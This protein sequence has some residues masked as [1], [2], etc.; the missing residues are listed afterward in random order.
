ML[1]AGAGLGWNGRVSGPPVVPL[2]TAR[3]LLLGAQGLLADPQRPATP[4][5]VHRQ[6]ERMGFVQVDTINVVERAHHHILLSRFD[7]YR[8]AMLAKLLERERSLFEHW[9]HDASV[10]PTRWFR[11]WKPRFARYRRPDSWPARR[12]RRIGSDAERVLDHVRGRIAREGPLMSK[13]FEHERTRKGRGWWDW[14]PQKT[15]LEFLWRTG[16][17]SIAARVNF[18]KVYELTERWLPELHRESPPGDEEHVEWACASALERLGVASA[19]ELQQFLG[20]IDLAAARR[21]CQEAERAGRIVRVVVESADA[22]APRPAFAPPDWE[23]RARRL[24]EA[25]PRARLLSPFDPVLRDRKRAQR[26]FGFD[27]TFEAFV[28]E[29]RRRFGYYVL[30]VLQGERL[31]GRVDAKLDRDRERLDVRRVWWEPGAGPVPARRRALRD[32]AERLAEQ[33]GAARVALPRS[34]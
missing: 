31:V 29:S 9:T 12:M 23:R 21:W 17:L 15:A 11:H 7:G 13:D 22:S 8:P 27:Y 2:Q 6:I 10:I 26:L 19:S 32:A 33:V 5:R 20:A 1:A 34:C 24:P 4:A 3:R 16:E 18:H 14:K 25:P 30:P 28:P